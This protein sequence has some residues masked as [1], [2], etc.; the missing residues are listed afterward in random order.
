MEIIVIGAGG[1]ATSL[2]ESILSCGHEILFFVDSYKSKDKLLGYKIVKNI[3]KSK[4]ILNIV[5][6]IGDNSNNTNNK[7]SAIIGEG[8]SSSSSSTTIIHT[9][10]D[11]KVEWSATGRIGVSLAQLSAVKEVSYSFKRASSRI[12][13][14]SSTKWG[15]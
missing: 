14:M 11:G 8:G 1:H 12:A 5:I 9:K 15:R 13:E 3:P 4:S 7:E 10:I 2:A 6:A